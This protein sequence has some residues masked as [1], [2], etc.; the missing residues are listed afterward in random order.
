M[1]FHDAKHCSSCGTALTPATHLDV[2]G[3]PCPRCS[4]GLV[5]HQVGPNALDECLRCGGVWVD[6][7]TFEALCL[8][9]ERQ[10]PLLGEAKPS[11]VYPVTYVP[12]P[13]CGSRM[14]R[15]NFGRVSGVIVDR[16]KLH[17]IWFDRDELRRVVEF[18]RHGGLSATRQRELEELREE[19]RRLESAR[20][21]PLE[22]HFHVES[23]DSHTLVD[24][25]L[26]GLR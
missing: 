9:N 25:L 17:G 3:R 14:N 19:R 10:L 18:I 4:A 26:S 21:A 24:W 5:A 13:A 22:P 6:V 2:E 16:C 15:E 1:M 7:A 20:S 12:C 8:E 23:R 11:E